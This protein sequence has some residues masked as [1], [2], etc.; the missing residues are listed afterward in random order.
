MSN[1]NAKLASLS[2]LFLIGNVSYVK[3]ILIKESCAYTET[4]IV[5]FAHR[6]FFCSRVHINTLSQSIDQMLY[7]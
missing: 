3:F 5:H 4:S 2:F 6:I 7:R 1:Q